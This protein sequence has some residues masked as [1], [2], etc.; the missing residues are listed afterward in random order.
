MRGLFSEGEDYL[1]RGG[2]FGEG[3]DCL[4]RIVW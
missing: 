4:V 1:V 2:L 3:E